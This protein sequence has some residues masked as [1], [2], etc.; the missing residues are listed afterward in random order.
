M[1]ADGPI[2]HQKLW[3]SYGVLTAAQATIQQ[4][5]MAQYTGTTTTVVQMNALVH[6]L[7]RVISI[8][9]EGI[10]ASKSAMQEP[11]STVH[12]GKI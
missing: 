3:N 5:T 7:E 1:N 6:W 4:R 8:F 2:Y 11:P 12:R 9:Q 10:S